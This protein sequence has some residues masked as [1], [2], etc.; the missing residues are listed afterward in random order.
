VVGLTSGAACPD[1]IASGLAEAGLARLLDIYGSSETGGVGW[2]ERTA[3]GWTENGGVHQLLPLW[4]QTGNGFIARDNE[5]P[6]VPPD[7]LRWDRSGGFRI[8]RRR[9]GA[10]MVGGVTVDLDRVCS[11][12]CAHPAIA[13][14]AVRP[15]QPAEG[16]RLKAFLV[17]HPEAGNDLPSLRRS[18]ATHLEAALTIPERPRAFRFGPALPLTSSGKPADWAVQDPDEQL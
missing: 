13:D 16:A 10:V 18:I 14:A 9:D 15:M 12:L 4:R 7:Y 17:P 1:A 3:G 5:A 8:G 11:V 2:R 6:I